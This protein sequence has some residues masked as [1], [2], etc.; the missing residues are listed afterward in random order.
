MTYLIQLRV[1]QRTWVVN[2]SG[3]WTMLVQCSNDK[4]ALL[5]DRIGI[6]FISVF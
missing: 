1:E 5:I 2:L 3:W 4:N 6:T